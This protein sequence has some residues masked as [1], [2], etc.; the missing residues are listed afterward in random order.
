M[1]IKALYIS[2]RQTVMVVLLEF[3]LIWIGLPVLVFSLLGWKVSGWVIFLGFIGSLIL[4]FVVC[5]KTYGLVMSFA[6]EKYGTLSFENDCIE[7]QIGKRKGKIDLKKPH[8][9]KICSGSSGLGKPSAQIDFRQTGLIIHLYKAM[10]EE[11]LDVFSDPYFVE[12]LSVLP[13]EGLWGFELLADDSEQKK[14]FF[15]MLESLWKNREKNTYFQSYAHYPWYQKPNPAFEYIKVIKTDSMTIE[16]KEFIDTLLTKF[17]DKFDDSYVR[18]TPDYL[19]GWAYKSLKS[20]WTGMPDYYCIMPIGHVSVEVSL[21][22]PD[23][24]PFIIG[25]LVMETLHS[26]GGPSRP[27]GPSL[28]D[29]RYLYI[30]GYD[31]HGKTLEMAFDWYELTHSL[32][33]ESQ[34]F[35]RFV[36]RISIPLRFE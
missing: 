29:R 30:R 5:V 7:Y 14:F 17:V 25:Q 27:Y 19:V 32:Y 18:T 36:N 9:V 20:T 23:W 1:K 6:K 2:G 21:P 33:E 22:M 34:R 4:A 8:D 13:E 3:L 10:R 28:Q 12:E 16:E 35:V 24:K 26:L 15:T 31:E 11:V